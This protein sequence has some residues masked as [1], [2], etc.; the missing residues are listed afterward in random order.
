MRPIIVLLFF[1]TRDNAI[2]YS[3]ATNT[4]VYLI[5]ANR[6]YNRFLQYATDAANN[7]KLYILGK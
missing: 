4:Y 3:A 7:L 5:Y 1:K 2:F 6:N